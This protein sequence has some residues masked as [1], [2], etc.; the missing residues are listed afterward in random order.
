MSRRFPSQRSVKLTALLL[1][2]AAPVGLVGCLKINPDYTALPHRDDAVQGV[3]SENSTEAQG[4]P[5]ITG[6]SSEAN[7]SSGQATATTETGP[8][9]PQAPD[10]SAPPNTKDSTQSDLTSV[11]SS[12]T[13]STSTT[14]TN[15]APA[16]WRAIEIDARQTNENV[17]DGYTLS[18]DIDHAAMVAS[19][20]SAN[21]SDL[22]IVVRRGGAFVSI[23]RVLDPE[24]SWN[25]NK[26]KLWFA[27]D[28]EVGRGTIRTDQYYLVIGDSSYPPVSDAKTLFLVFDDFEETNV[29]PSRW[30]SHTSSVGTRSITK[31]GAGQRLTAHKDPGY[32]LVYYSIRHT[33]SAYPNGVRV[34]VK[35][36]FNYFDLLGVCGRIFPFALKSENNDSIRASLRINLLDYD[37]LSFDDIQGIN[38]VDQINSG[39]PTDG[40]W[41]THSL[42]WRG[43]EMR[44]YENG[45]Q[46]IQTQG[47]GTVLRPDQTPLSLEIS[48]GARSVDC[49]GNGHIQLD[50]DW[51][52][53]RADMFPAPSARLQ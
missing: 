32:P 27:L 33:A 52:R 26:T 1:T 43:Q 38:Q 16:S 53:V 8:S 51:V 14:D 48:S 37:V 18:L 44:Y 23:N 28:G 4:K 45:T 13:Q 12:G 35:S 9:D 7:A 6:E 10:T 47:H 40:P 17:A 39:F 25:Q 5:N 46:L 11:S 41:T 31:I 49:G 3:E 21:G 2:L 20:A 36:R 50:V 30:T 19:G 24:S 22:S 42:T 15:P 29:D 34:D